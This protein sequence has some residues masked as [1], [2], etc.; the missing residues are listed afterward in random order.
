MAAL[1]TP[2]V[3]APVSVRNGD[4]IRA[5]GGG[6]GGAT[7]RAAALCS[8][9]LLGAAAVL[10]S[11]SERP[12]G[13]PAALG[14]EQQAWMNKIRQQSQGM[15]PEQ[16]FMTAIKSGMMAASDA[17]HEVKPSARLALSRAPAKTQRLQEVFQ[18]LQAAA[19]ADAAPA[20]P[21]GPPAEVTEGAEG[22][23]LP[24]QAEVAA[25]AADAQVPEQVVEGQE[26]IADE[27]VPAD[28]AQAAD[29]QAGVPAGMR[30]VAGIPV[31]MR[32]V[33]GMQEPNKPPVSVV[34][35][36]SPFQV[37]VQ[38][39]GV[40]I[41]ENAVAMPPE[42]F[43]GGGWAE[44]TIN[45]MPAPKTITIE[46]KKSAGEPPAAEAPVGETPAASEPVGKAPAAAE[47]AAG[48]INATSADWETSVAAAAPVPEAGVPAEIG[49]TMPVVADSQ[50]AS[51]GFA[52]PMIGAARVP[53]MGQVMPAV[54]YLS[55]QSYCALGKK[56]SPINIELD[57]VQRP[58]PVL[59]WQVTSGATAQFRAVPLTINGM[60]SGRALMLMGASALMPVGG[61]GYALQSVYLH[62][63]SE[64]AVAGQKFDMEMQFL[65]TAIVDGVQKFVV[66]SAFGRKS[67]ESAP[68]LAQLAASLPTD[69]TTAETTVNL[70]LAA[71][72]TQVLGQT[73]MVN[74]TA[75]NAQSYYQY[76][77]SVTSAPCTEGVTWLVLKNPLPVSA[78]DLDLLAKYLAQ[79]SRPIQPLNG[80]FV[81]TTT[82]G[83]V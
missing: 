3:V 9:V 57:I 64:H 45:G 36:G 29:A 20:A 14:E 19:P 39:P 38:S 79:P 60:L 70:D 12:G 31:G 74:P 83:V 58:L 51:M 42:A 46:V 47:P 32:M 24:P 77:G 22:E 8:F 65:H 33:A 2:E 52:V 73:E 34:F 50:P 25:E 6:M 69:F 35:Q 48:D 21:A 75:T 30:I 13:G 53:E 37:P 17:Q 78:S 5:R 56:Q 23:S 16:M 26:K 11:Q 15:P 4:T 55:V 54:G 40:G 44:E 68:F 41:V 27:A 1:G 10:V 67:M 63:S 43:Q 49:A 81:L 76:D 61:V 28:D 18:R 7:R 62:T 82:G 72:A 71:I 66:V 59:L 80:R